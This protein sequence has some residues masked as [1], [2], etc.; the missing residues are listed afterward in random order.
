[1]PAAGGFVLTDWRDQMANL[2]DPEE[3]ACYHTPDEAP[4]LARH[5]LAHPR[6]RHRIITAA[7]K[8][9]LACHTWQQRLQTMLTHMRD[10]YG[11][12][13]AQG[14]SHGR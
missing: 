4:E 9:V 6:E 12:P 5:F 7:R 1:V 8:R 3:M 10:I 2:F 14:P 11:T 13:R